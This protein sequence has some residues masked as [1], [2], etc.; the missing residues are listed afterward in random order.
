[1]I[2]W[3]YQT[4][5]AFLLF[6]FT[7]L[8]TFQNVF[9]SHPYNTVSV[10]SYLVKNIVIFL[11]F[12]TFAT[13]IP[14]NARQVISHN[15]HNNYWYWLIWNFTIVIG[16]SAVLPRPSWS[17][18]GIHGKCSSYHAQSG[19]SSKHQPE[20]IKQEVEM[21]VVGDE[22]DDTVTKQTVTLMTGDRKWCHSVIYSPSCFL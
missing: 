4:V 10:L 18:S 1:M 15:L 19:Q 7:H 11:H 21:N 5:L 2:F 6:T 8:S 22:E 9:D 14:S 20:D 16:F 13:L 17:R 3:T 12:S